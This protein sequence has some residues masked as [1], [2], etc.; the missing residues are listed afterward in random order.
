MQ[1]RSDNMMWSQL[2]RLSDRFEH[3]RGWID[4]LMA[5]DGLEP[6]TP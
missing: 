1:N 4:R 6:A 2:F 3:A 5:L